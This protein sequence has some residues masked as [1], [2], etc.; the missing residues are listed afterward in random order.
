MVRRM[1]LQDPLKRW[2]G[3]V[4]V[5]VMIMGGCSLGRDRA[6]PMQ[7]EV[8]EGTAQLIRDGKTSRVRKVVT[9]EVG[10]RIR[11]PVGAIAE[12]RLAAGRDFE[13]AAADVTIRSRSSLQLDRGNV[14]ADLTSP[15]RITTDGVSASASNSAFRIDRSLSTRLAVYRSATGVAA[16][17]DSD[18]LNVPALRQTIV[19]GGI[20]DVA[21]PLRLTST[22]RWDRRY[23]QEVIDLD[24]RLINF[25]RGLEAQLGD[26][27]GMAFFQQVAVGGSDVAFLGSY[28]GHRRA[29]I[30]IGLVIAAEAK[31]LEGT[32]PEKFASIFSLWEEEATW[33]LIA[34]EFG[35]EAAG[36]FARLLEAIDRAGIRIVAG[37]GPGLRRAQA[38]GPN[39]GK[40][41]PPPGGNGGT[42]PSPGQ[43]PSPSA[44]IPSPISSIVPDEV[45]DPVNEVICGLIGAV[46]SP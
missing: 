45:E 24:A 3:I 42:G 8:I 37:V 5:V 27:S 34:Y 19:A 13:I 22:D 21:R 29:D 18:S 17:S 7:L 20:L 14:L 25:G 4:A 33:G 44:P 39:N 9:V 28:A 11:L 31:K 43:S 10:D 35:A 41:S 1:Y 38:Q 12:L 40:G 30:L 2:T 46:C 26:L 16:T 23:L 15:A 36:V 6:A 32:V